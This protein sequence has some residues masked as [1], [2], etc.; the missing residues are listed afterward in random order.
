MAQMEIELQSPICPL[1]NKRTIKLV[2]KEDDGS[3]QKMCQVCKRK[4]RDGKTI[5]RFDRSS[6][7]FGKLE[8]EMLEKSKNIVEAYR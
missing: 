1:C 2:P 5:E 3:G 4:L 8:A 7:N 6:I